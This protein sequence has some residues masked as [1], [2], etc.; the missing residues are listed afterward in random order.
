M[1]FV[2]SPESKEEILKIEGELYNYLFKVRRFKK[3]EIVPFRNLKDNFLYFY[4]IENV[5]RREAT[6]KLIEKEEKI[7][8]SPTQLHLFWCIIDPKTIEKTLPMLNEIGVSKIT[9]IYCER[10][11]KN[12]K[13]DMKRLKRILISSSMQCGRSVLPQIEIKNSLEEII[14]EHEDLT[15]LDFCDKNEVEPE[16]IKKIIVGAEGGFTQK[17]REMLSKNPKIGFNTPL[18]LKSET[19]A[20]SICSKILI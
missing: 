10:S 7:V 1:R 16:N 8:T 6:L 5:A 11:Q 12:F 19:A 17:E 14:K 4:K 2:F 18:I 13:L 15:V 20:V 3:G 9:F